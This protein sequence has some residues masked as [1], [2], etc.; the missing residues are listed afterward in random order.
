MSTPMRAQ[1]ASS[2]LKFALL[3]SALARVRAFLVSR[4]AGTGS[5]RMRASEYLRTEPTMPMGSN[6]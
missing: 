1:V 6:T 4:Q 2:P 3:T 5:Q